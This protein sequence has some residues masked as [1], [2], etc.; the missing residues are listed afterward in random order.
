MEIIKPNEAIS[1][2]SLH[3]YNDIGEW[4]GDFSRAP[5]SDVKIKEFQQKIDQAFGVNPEGKSQIVLAWSGD[6]TF[7]EPFYT[8]W[9]LNGLPIE[10]S[11]EKQP[12]LL[13]FRYKVND[14]DYLD[15][16]PPRW[17]LLER[18]EPAQYADSWKESS[19]AEDG[20]LGCE[21][22]LRPDDPPKDYYVWYQTLATHDA[23]TNIGYLP[24]CCARSRKAQKKCF[25]KYR[26]PNEADLADLRRFRQW[27]EDNNCQRAD[28]PLTAESLR[29]ISIATRF[30]IDQA[31]KRKIKAM[32]EWVMTNPSQFLG[33]F[34][35][36]RD[37]QLSAREIDESVSDGLEI[38]EQEKYARISGK[39]GDSA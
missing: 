22:M 24:P 39:C 35:K 14:Y 3:P 36:D 16:Y 32:R 33:S 20:R 27:R 23:P 29:K 28:E 12:I 11:L 37:C 18:R 25:G 2:E 4:A 21:K 38:I 19:W 8:D 15:L 34:M 26:E 17:I 30:S 13:F 6:R 31:E 9:Y 7:W 10:S 5:L 1:T